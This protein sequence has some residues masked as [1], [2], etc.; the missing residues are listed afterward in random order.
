[1]HVA[2]IIPIVT[3]LGLF[4]SAI[5]HGNIFKFLVL[6]FLFINSECMYANLLILA[7]TCEYYWSPGVSLGHLGGFVAF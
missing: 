5:G 4:G 2:C 6:K 3:F 7:V 1:M